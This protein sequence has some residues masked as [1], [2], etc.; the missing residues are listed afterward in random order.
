[1][2]RYHVHL[3]ST[4]GPFAVVSSTTYDTLQDAELAIVKHATANGMTRVQEIDDDDSDGYET[5]WTAT[6]A[7]GRRGR[8]IARLVVD[9]GEV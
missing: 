4:A 5:R 1:M 9:P 8:N 7:H 6:T 2:T 3:Y